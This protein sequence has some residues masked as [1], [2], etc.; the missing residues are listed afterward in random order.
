MSQPRSAAATA[1]GNGLH[2]RGGSEDRRSAVQDSAELA[3]LL[4]EHHGRVYNVIFRMVS[5]RDDADELTQ[6]VM[7]KVV[8]NADQFRGEAQPTT[9]ITRIAINAAISHLRKRRTRRAVSLESN[10]QATDDEAGSLRTCLADH[11]EPDGLSSVEQS[12]EVARL[13]RAIASL[14]DDFR[15]VLVLRDIDEMDY[16]QIAE[17][18]E[19]KVGTVKSRLFRARLALRQTLESTPD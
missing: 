8:K 5:N 6:D 4:S 19:I 10:G 18:L 14:D 11:R 17:T 7:L 12:E 16:A 2:L 3:N 13:Q 1:T 15:S 9:W